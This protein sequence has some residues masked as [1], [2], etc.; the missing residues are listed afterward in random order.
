[1]TINLH[2]VHS[3]IHCIKGRVQYFLIQVVINKCFS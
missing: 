2:V 1:M 3:T